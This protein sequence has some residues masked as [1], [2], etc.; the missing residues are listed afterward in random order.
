MVWAGSAAES[1]AARGEVLFVGYGATAPEYKWN[2]FKGCGY[3]RE[4]LLVLVNDLRT[5]E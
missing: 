3:S 2:D 4:D 1:S 5:P